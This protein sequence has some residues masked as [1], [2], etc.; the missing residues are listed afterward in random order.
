MR[1]MHATKL[2][3]YCCFFLHSKNNACSNTKL[4]LSFS[5]LIVDVRAIATIIIAVIAEYQI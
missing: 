2:F 5:A 4:Q 3:C 1:I